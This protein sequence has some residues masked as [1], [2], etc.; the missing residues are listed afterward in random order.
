MPRTVDVDP[1]ADLRS[2]SG[3]L[4][5]LYVRRPAP[6][7][8][9]ALL[10]DLLKPIRG[11]SEEADREVVLAVRGDVERIRELAGRFEFESAPSYVVFASQL[12]G[13]FAVEPLTHE[14]PD[15]AMI[16][17][18]PYLRPLRAAPRA[19]RCGVLVADHAS[20]RV[21][22]AS[23]RVVTEIGRPFAA[24]IGKPNFGGFA[25][26]DEQGA[27]SR[28]EVE[29][30]RMWKQAA[31]VLLAEHR[32]KSFDYVAIGSREETT[33]DLVRSLH[34]Y[35]AALPRVVFPAGPGSVTLQTLRVQLASH[36]LE[37]SRR[38]Q[39][40]IATRVSEVARS[41]GNAV[42][43]LGPTL[44]AANLGA[45]DTLVVAGEF[46]KPGAICSSCSRLSRLGGECA[47][48]GGDTFEI[49][50]VVAAIME[51]TVDHGGVVHQIEVA[52]PLDT[53]GIGALTRFPVPVAAG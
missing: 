47:F 27:R 16:G 19:L 24:D 5:T 33:D 53:E 10:T 18:R 31:E 50:D 38:G 2:P 21:F 32:S 12:D 40:A 46:T 51:S 30:A 36:D 22:V 35:L 23:G 8:F 43:G 6:G 41:G 15:V 13:V 28:A 48:C 3:S 7:G 25:G 52:S 26:Y 20:A 45:V 4:I 34:P 49:D 1:I 29:T 9:A 11:R 39:D 14:T 42:L 17:P 37:V 44:G